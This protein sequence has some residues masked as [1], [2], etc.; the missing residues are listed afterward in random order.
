MSKTLSRRRFLELATVSGGALAT[1]CATN[2]V[3]GRSQLMLM[4]ES[5]E[6]AMDQ[7]WAAHQF[8]TDYGPSQDEALNA[9][10]AGIGSELAQRSHRPHMPY[11]FRG[12]NSVVANAY[13]FPAGSIGVTRGLMLAMESEAELASVLGHELGHVSYRHA[14]ER[15]SK[16]LL[17]M[18]VVAGVSAYVA[19]EKEE[20]ADLAA[21]LGGVG[22]NLLLS[23]YSRADE[24]EADAMGLKYM[25]DAG[26]NPNGMVGLM[27]TLMSL[28]EHE[29]SVVE[30]LFSTHP[31]SRERYETASAEAVGTYAF[32]SK[33][34]EHR[35]RHMDATAALRGMRKAIEGM[36]QGQKEMFA[37]DYGAAQTSFLGALRAEPDDYACLLLTAKCYMAQDRGAA[38][39]PYIEHAREV[40]P[41]EPHADQLSGMVNLGAGRFSSALSDF[42][43]YDQRLPGNANT[44]FHKGFCL[45][46]LGRKEEAAEEYRRY[47][48]EDP[49]GDFSGF[50]QQR[51]TEWGYAPA[52]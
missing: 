51:M 13:T 6:I 4:S 37:K 43:A 35:E 26:Y 12:V 20:Y 11:S 2:P 19:S 28:N 27:E 1:G 50:V 18:A 7:K 38:A 10:I 34:P 3:T 22:A 21:G 23:R 36:Q 44:A 8:S 41:G 17:A 25:T 31:L 30:L 39:Q 16:G 46:R 42:S 47:A 24:R 14:G 45:D 40:Y 9:Y 32:A 49:S 52:Q 48:Q 5:Q 33:Y 29:P 15:M